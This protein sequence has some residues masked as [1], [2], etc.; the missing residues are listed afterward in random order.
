MDTSWVNVSFAGAYCRMND[1]K[2]KTVGVF[3]RHSTGL[4]MQCRLAADVI[5][6]KGKMKFGF[7][8]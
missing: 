1:Q 6:Q 2:S 4:R 5:F 8:L 7:L 3:F